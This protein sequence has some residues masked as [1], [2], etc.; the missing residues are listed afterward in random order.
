MSSHYLQ[1][2]VRCLCLAL[3][4]SLYA[5]VESML[6]AVWGTTPNTHKT[7]RA[8][9]RRISVGS[10]PLKVG[11]EGGRKNM[12]AGANGPEYITISRARWEIATKRK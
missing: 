2:G 12:R 3:L 10:T 9:A 6:C 1:V 4:K 11:R 7:R 8:A 5:A